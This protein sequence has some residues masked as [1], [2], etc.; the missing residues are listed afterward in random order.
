[1]PNLT[2]FI[3]VHGRLGI[4][5]AELPESATFS[6]LNKLIDT[7][8]VERDANTVIFVDES[9]NHLQGDEN[10]RIGHIRHGSRVHVCHCRR[11]RVKVHF[12]DKTVEHEFVPGARVRAVK[13]FAVQKFGLNP[14]DAAEH[15]LQLCGSTKRPATDTPLNE[16]LGKHE[17]AL[18]FDLI[19]EK[20]VEGAHE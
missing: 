18:C 17:C 12:T 1:M 20:R 15:V 8:G 19:P 2:V 16:V 9:E 3:Q 10:A 5:E 6:E 13:E 11:V 4:L 14:K 7:L